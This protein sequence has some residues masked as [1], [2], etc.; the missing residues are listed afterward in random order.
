MHLIIYFMNEVISSPKGTLE[1]LTLVLAV[2]ADQTRFRVLQLLL[3][4]DLCV[5]ALARELAIS[6]PAVSQ[7]LKKLR[8][9]GLV[10]GE[11]RGYWVH[12]SVNSEVLMKAS[13]ELH[14]LALRQRL[15]EGNCIKRSSGEKCCC[16]APKNDRNLQEL[17][18]V[19]HL[20]G[21]DV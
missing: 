12:Y 4:R 5:G 21:S 8:K 6:E 17:R 16:P 7:H 10:T 3:E 14:R 11:K 19:T 1:N 9:C 13:D 18:I 15:G 20:E 2:L